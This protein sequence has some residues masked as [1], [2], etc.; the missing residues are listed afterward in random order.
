MGLGSGNQIIESGARFRAARLFGAYYDLTLQLKERFGAEDP[1]DV[2]MIVLLGI[3]DLG[4][5]PMDAD[6]LAEKLQTSR[7][8]VDRRLRRFLDAGVVLK[9]RQ[10]KLTVFRLGP[11]VIENSD[12]ARQGSIDM[13]REMVRTVMDLVFDL[14]SDD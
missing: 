10:G 6:L 13:T 14:T 1:I 3:G 4:G 11:N 2:V 8:T 9:E 5:L 7:S 12:V